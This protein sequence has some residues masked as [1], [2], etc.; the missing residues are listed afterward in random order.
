MIESEFARQLDGHGVGAAKGVTIVFDEPEIVLAAELENGGDREGIAQGVGDHNSLGFAR[1]I[2]SLQ[3]LGANVSSDRV[4]VE[5]DG[6]GSGLNDRRNR[7]RKPCRDCDNLVAR[8]NAFVRRQLVG[9][10]C[11]E[12]NEI[13]RGPGIDEQRVA[14]AEDRREFLLESLALGPEREPEIQRG[15]DGGLHLVFGEDPTGVRNSGFAGDKS[16]SVRIV[17]RAVGG[18]KCAGVGA[19]R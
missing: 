11:G 13:G 6:Y 16:R 9:G 1:R 12:R 18:V 7:G 17:A 5:K 19:R 3:L 8:L 10:E 14:D 15:R 4:V 2:G